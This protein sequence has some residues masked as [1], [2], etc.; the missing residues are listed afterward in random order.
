MENWDYRAVAY[1]YAGSG[2]EPLVDA[3]AEILHYNESLHM[4][5]LGEEDAQHGACSY[6]WLRAGRSVR[7]VLAAQRT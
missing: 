4:H 5:T 7:V 6:C 2:N 1:K 3:V